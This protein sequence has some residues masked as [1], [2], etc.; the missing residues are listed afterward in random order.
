VTAVRDVAKSYGAILV[1]V[2]LFL[3]LTAVTDPVDRGERTIAAQAVLAPGQAPP[4]Q[5]SGSVAE[6]QAAA[7]AAAQGGGTAGGATGTGY[8]GYV[9][10]GAAACPD[11]VVQ[12]PGDPYT[13]P[14]FVRDGDNGGTTTR[15]VTADTIK[16]A[17][18]QVGTADAGE[19][20]AEVGGGRRLSSSPEAYR[21]TLL[22]LAEYFNTRFEMYGRKI[23]IVFYDGQGNA[24]TELLGG[25]REQALSDATRAAEELQ[26]FADLSAIT[27][28]YADS[29]AR[30]GV[31]NFGAP[32]P[33]R[34]WFDERAPFSWSIFPDGTRV[35]EAA[36]AQIINRIGPG[37]TADHAGPAFKGKPRKYALIAPENA[38][39]QQS[40]NRYTEILARAGMNIDLNIKYRLDISSMPNQA[41]NIIAQ[42]KD[43]GITSVLAGTDPVMLA[44]GLTPKADEQDYE[45]E[46]IT[47]GL[48]FVEQDIVGQLMSP[49]QWAHAFGIAFNAESEPIGGSFPYAAYKSVRP[50]DEP[51]FGVEELYYQMYMLAVGIQMAGPNLTPETLRDGMYAYPGGSGP[52]GFWKFGPGD[53]TP[54]D[55]F[56]EIYWDG[57]VI[58]PQTNEPGAW[59]QLNGGARYFAD[60]VPKAPAPY[61]QG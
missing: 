47:A 57:N 51:A 7:A 4:A 38:E 46:W 50:N 14:C 36:S 16:V 2:V 56:R 32:Y 10:S 29:L 22:A 23:E 60:T 8:T 49:R 35:V 25:G 12:V 28:P 40:V 5:G 55:D 43:A 59:V 27:L 30:L 58:S 33:S 54:P 13:P 24:S 18:R 53:H 19:A 41:S 1:A 52:R 15:G 6:Q 44:L 39:Y 26:V 34:E 61:F 3:G 9:P 21:Q 42:L 45:P 17:I 31:V 37:S 48:A 20:L 11:R